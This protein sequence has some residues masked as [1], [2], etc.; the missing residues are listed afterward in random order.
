MEV[1]FVGVLA[2]VIGLFHEV[3]YK[4]LP[5]PIIPRCKQTRVFA[6]INT[7]IVD[8]RAEFPV[9]VVLEGANHL[10]GSLFDTATHQGTVTV[11]SNLGLA[12]M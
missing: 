9:R 11:I 1:N 8:R 5:E 4:H 3:F 12:I 10:E 6:N 7:E 2:S